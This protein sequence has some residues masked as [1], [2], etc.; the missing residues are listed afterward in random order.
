MDEVVGVDIRQAEGP[1][2]PYEVDSLDNQR[3]GEDTVLDGVGLVHEVAERYRMAVHARVVTD[4]REVEERR[5]SRDFPSEKE[6]EAW[7]RVGVS[8]AFP[9]GRRK[10]EGG[11]RGGTHDLRGKTIWARRPL[12][13]DQSG[14]ASGLGRSRGV[15]GAS[16]KTRADYPPP[17]QREVRAWD[18][19][20]CLQQWVNAG[21][22]A[23]A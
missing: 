7:K 18:D 12:V 15:E 19:H 8:A 4:M 2:V 16:A 17:D 9:F 13:V 6:E 20:V 10:M 11:G 5:Y 23:S 3:V 21:H 14:G 1:S 22:G